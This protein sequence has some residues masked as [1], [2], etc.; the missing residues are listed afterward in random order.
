MKY[1]SYFLNPPDS[2]F[3]ILI[4]ILGILILVL[5]FF[6]NNIFIAIVDGSSMENTIHNNDILLVN[7]KAYSISSPQ[8]YDIINVYAPYKYDNFL[9]KR[10]IAL[11]GDI[12]EI[13]NS[14]L[15]INGEE[16][17][18][19]YIKETMTLQYY[20]K[21]KVPKDKYFVMGDNRNVSLDSRYF[22]LIS[23]DDIQGKV[24]IKY[25]CKNHKFS[26]FN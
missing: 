20:L 1:S 17:H 7:K 14:S 16:I 8:R 11:P 26:L 19:N 5:A 21:L 23:L 22:G 9:V 10:I 15:Y 25:C 4:S 13:D 3:K 6:L 24:M 2:F 12:I 18:E